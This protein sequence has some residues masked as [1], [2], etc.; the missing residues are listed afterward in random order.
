MNLDGSPLAIEQAS[1]D[2]FMQGP[3]TAFT[4][5]A[6]ISK[7]QDEYTR[8]MA[9]GPDHF[10]CYYEKDMSIIS[11][12]NIL[13]KALPQYSTD[14]IDLLNLCSCLG[15]NNIPMAMLTEYGSESQ[16]P[17]MDIAPTI[18]GAVS[19]SQSSRIF[20]WA[21][22]LSEE[23][24]KRAIMSLLKFSCIKVRFSNDKIH[25]FWVENAIRRWCQGVL[26]VALKEEW[27][28]V[29]AHTV[30]QS[31][32]LQEGIIAQR[33]YLPI[34]QYCDHS[35]F[36]DERFVEIQAP[37]GGFCQESWLIS[38][39]FARF[40]YLHKA[41]KEAHI[42]MERAVNY[43]RLIRGDSW[44]TDT[45]SI[46]RYHALATYIR[47][48]GDHT[49][50]AQ[51]FV[52]VLTICKEVIG[53]DDALT[54]EIANQSSTLQRRM[55]H[56][57]QLSLQASQARG[58]KRRVVDRQE[59]P[60]SLSQNYNVDL[61][62]Y[63]DT[64][65]VEE[66]ETEEQLELRKALEN[67]RHAH[68]HFSLNTVIAMSDL[69]HAYLADGN[70]IKA[71]PQ[72]ESVLTQYFNMA[73]IEPYY[74]YRAI[75][76]LCI[77]MGT[78]EAVQWP[79]HLTDQMV[80][81]A[82][83]WENFP[84]G[85]SEHEERQLPGTPWQSD[86]KLSQTVG[87][88]KEAAIHLAARIGNEK[89]TRLL[90]E[91]GADITAT[92]TLGRTPLYL[93]SCL[94]QKRVVEL[95]IEKGAD[96]NATNHINWTAIHAAAWNGRDLVVELLLQL[97]AIIEAQDEGGRTP[98]LLA[99]S[100]GYL[101]VVQLLLAWGA[102]PKPKTGSGITPLLL[103]ANGGH[104]E[105]VRLLQAQEPEAG[106]EYPEELVQLLL[107][108]GAKAKD[109]GL[110]RSGR[111][112]VLTSHAHKGNKLAVQ[113][114]LDVGV[115]IEVHD[116]Y[117]MAALH[118]AVTND[119][120]E[121][122]QLLLDRGANIDIRGYSGQTPLICAVRLGREEVVKLLLD[123]GAGLEV[124]T[125]GGL[126]PLLLAAE[127][128]YKKVVQL[129]MARGA[130]TDAR[131]DHGQ[132]PLILAAYNGHKEVAQFLV[133]QGANVEAQDQ[134]GRTALH[135]AV[136]GV[137]LLIPAHQDRKEVVQFLLDTGADIEA[138]DMRQRTALHY[139][140]RKG[141]EDVIQL[142]L[143]HGA[144]I[145]AEDDENFTALQNATVTGHR[146]VVQLLLEQGAKHRAT[147]KEQSRDTAL[148]NVGFSNDTELVELP[149]QGAMR[150]FDDLNLDL[151]D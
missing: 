64:V 135:H 67:A 105:M 106:Q 134:D 17:M 47:D 103:A 123:R 149:D 115:E 145:E 24:L 117:G 40:Y 21:S 107:D 108:D 3:L 93:A 141:L 53:S 100:C 70:W 61:P 99:A 150:C 25:S 73:E 87:Q 137:A 18:E 28:I 20:R 38:L 16:D 52:S 54:L 85:A 10:E 111:Y 109:G 77:Y 41:F 121:V 129:L 119:H 110:W 113:L 59:E 27:S 68:G 2:I 72:I 122:V 58:E 45:P 138:R 124:E 86:N 8:L 112:S 46:I 116:F 48:D 29:A 60:T 84:A 15:R 11:T 49:K 104:E 91:K 7:L 79:P 32:I 132:T 118:W 63:E 126:T 22:K 114:L 43:E 125:D 120:L 131:N 146:D 5:R 128:G 33:N 75:N 82:V 78:C 83:A 74:R 69:A 12:F 81:K 94:G 90:L 42:S 19:S 39:R 148:P 76:Y 95:L 130:K 4:L 144:N 136:E 57:A 66:E 14:A 88:P 36:S 139:A 96:I 6:Y 140:A 80:S 30:S 23:S 31:L 56:D 55:A 50:A 65:V 151:Y 35:L 9:R 143:Q 44:L 51:I 62:A 97:G 102:D 142:L 37:D 98:L 127:I 92:D 71:K 101:E 34:L 13:E 26:P 89:L 147:Y 133:G 1:A